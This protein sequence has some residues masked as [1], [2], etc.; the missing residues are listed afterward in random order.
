MSS[1]YVAVLFDED[2][3]VNPGDSFRRESD[4]LRALAAI[5]E[6]V[7]KRWVLQNLHRV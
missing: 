5:V 2:D 1:T 4:C 6:R 7:G 3:N